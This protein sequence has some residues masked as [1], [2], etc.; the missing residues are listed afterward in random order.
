MQT[1]SRAFYTSEFYCETQEVAMWRQLKKNNH[2]SALV[3]LFGPVAILLVA[4][5]W[6]AAATTA[7]SNSLSFG[8][9]AGVQVVDPDGLNQVPIWLT[10][11]NMTVDFALY[12]LTPE[13]FID[14]VASDPYRPPTPPPGASPV[15][16]WQQT[17]G[18]LPT[19]PSMPDDVAMPAGIASGLYILHA[20]HPQAGT[21]DVYV[22]VGRIA[23]A[24]KRA[25]GQAI[26][27]ATQLQQ[28]TPTPGMTV[29]IYDSEA[30]VL[31]QAVTDDAGVARLDLGPVQPFLA[32]ARLGQELALV[33]LDWSWTGNMIGG[34][35]WWI[36]P[37]GDHHRVYIHSDR[38]IYRPGDV[39]HYQAFV[40]R[41]EHGELAPVAPSAPITVTL[42]DARNN[43]AAQQQLSADEFGAVYGDFHLGDGASLGWYNIQLNVDGEWFY[44]SLR[45]EEYRKPEYQVAVSVSPSP[46]ISGDPVQVTVQADYFFG[47][48]VAGADVKLSVRRQ[49][50][51]YN[52]H[53]WQWHDGVW[54]PNSVVDE[55]TGVTDANGRYTLTYTPSASADWDSLY[56]FSA[57]VTDE[58]NTPIAGSATLPVHWAG[59]RLE[60]DLP[61][62]GYQIGTPVTAIIKAQE[63]SGAPATNWEITAQLTRE[64]Y[65]GGS[66]VTLPPQVVVTG[67]DGRVQVAFTELVQG[68]YRLTAS[69][70]DSRGRS[71]SANSYFWVFDSKEAQWWF[72]SSDQLSILPDKESYVPGDTA[73]L[74]IQST[75]TGTALLTFEREEVYHEQIV[76]IA[77]PVTQVDAPI[78]EDFA[79]NMH[80]RLHLF[81]PTKP[82]DNDR[83]AE[84]TLYMAQTELIVPATHKQLTLTIAKNAEKFLPGSQ[85]Q[86]ALLATNAQ[87]Q[88]VQARVGLA[89]VDEAIFALQSDLSGD[90]FATFYDRRA[91]G[92]ETFHS[93]ARKPYFWRGVPT[94]ATPSPEAPAAEGDFGGQQSVEPRTRFEDTAFWSAEI[95]TGVDGRATV[96]VTLP[97]N[98]TTWHIVARAIT[99]DG[100]VGQAQSSLLVTKDVV[101]RLATPRFAV[102]GDRFQ[103]QIIGNN[104]TGQP[105]TGQAELAAA[106]LTLLD[107][108]PRPL[109]LPNGNADLGKWTAIA[110]TPG[111][112]V[113]TAAVQTPVGGDALALPLAIKPFSALERWMSA[114]AA[115]LAASESFTFPLNAIPT[116]SSLT[117]R[118]APS[119]AL[120]VL[121]GLDE[122]IDY[123]YGCVE[124][125]MSRLLPSAVAAQAYAQLG[126]PNPKADELPK[127][128]TTGLQKLY[129]FQQANGSWGWFY[130]DDGGLYMTSYVLLGLVEVQKAGFPVDVGV[131]DRGFLYVN[132][133]LNANSDPSV[134]AFALYVKALAG[135]G[136]LPKAQTLLNRMGEI[137]SASLALLAVALQEGG[138][139]AGAQSALAHLLSRV[140]ETAEWAFW[141]VPKEEWD[142]R[143]WQRLP[144]V[145][146]NTASALQTLAILQPDHPLL[147]KVVR[148]LM[149][150]R[151]DAG[152]GNTQ[153]TAFAVMGLA[154]TILA[155]GEMQ[156][157]YAYSVRLNDVEIATGQV[158]PQSIMTPIAP[159]FVPGEALQPGDNLLRIERSAG[160]GNLYYS[161]MLQRQLFFD[162][163]TPIAAAESGLKVTRAYALAEGVSR[164]DGAYNVGDLVEVALTVETSSEL[165]Y[166]LIEDPIPAGFEAL[167]ERLNPMMYGDVFWE[168]TWQCWGYNQKEVRDD[169]VEFFVTRLWPGTH[170]FRYLMRATTPGDYS[171]PPSQVIAMYNDAIWGRSASQRVAVAPEQL[172][173]HAPFLGDLD[174]SCTLTVMDTRLAA[175]AWGLRSAREDIVPDGIVTL[176]DVTVIASRVGATCAADRPLL[177]AGSGAGLVRI[178]VDKNAPTTGDRFA[179][180]VSLDAAS[181]ALGG[182]G[183]ALG[184]DPAHMRFV[185]AA[186]NDD[187]ALPLGPRIDRKKG[188]L[189]AGALNLH[190]PMSAGATILRLNF[191]ALGVGTGEITVLGVE[192]ADSAG[193][194]LAAQAIGGESVTVTG[195]RFFLPM[196]RQ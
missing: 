132:N 91:S 125:T 67:P 63:H 185:S 29:T 18:S 110:S 162:H 163:L 144:S 190:Q 79:P 26:V 39:I 140:N 122:L 41:N 127:I 196:L 16:T 181:V 40:R 141:P 9:S 176:Q 61:R 13:D 27:W 194:T 90:P 14:Q 97:D 11:P 48:P 50:Y 178:V 36:P 111:T 52:W 172:A 143:W 145:E 123:P 116:A 168:C 99:V 17:F 22:A 56:T 32:T 45:V 81:Q 69:A 37:G 78:T 103:A 104:Y 88:G 151:R 117:V 120:G 160:P 113:F 43:L 24:A 84:G 31:G 191:Q 195:Q 128:M 155:R 152:W 65:S 94:L 138:D 64:S 51:S 46:A 34:S 3:A 82:D 8:Y 126:L 7:Q 167:Y 5:L 114:G 15:T 135:R 66:D 180:D 62:Y 54:T 25:T 92:V 71:V 23:L 30:N 148:W 4:M 142:W 157:D 107:A 156:S 133:I 161:A 2:F 20:S 183:V 115:N 175:N 106:G 105:T 119:F 149:E 86:I 118:L 171:V 58:R 154:Q 60:I 102:V 28:Q 134:Q 98:L 49:I 136:D 179:V 159:I 165:A 158:T 182:V 169:R 153:A 68:W 74:L 96:D 1:C 137:D 147:P 170:S 33:G 193:R 42:R 184:F 109:N 187:D 12:T 146:K 21:A 38:P 166:V 101:T 35:W 130:D 73:H 89:L 19:D 87:G 173:D 108:G 164:A 83:R 80:L 95:T 77:G 76:T 6:G 192:A 188:I 121:D 75:F 129:G 100:S 112:G 85:A 177:G 139:N 93:L 189:L 174:R 72:S 59:L 70:V 53:W 44:Q 124:Q 47:Q 57:T 55:F 150:H 10:Q 186:L 131:L